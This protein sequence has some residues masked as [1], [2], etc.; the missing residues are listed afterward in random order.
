MDQDLD[1]QALDEPGEASAPKKGGLP[2]GGLIRMV[3]R[4]IL[5]IGGMTGAL[6]IA[7]WLSTASD[8][9]TYRGN[10]QLLVEP[11][12]SEARIA[13]PTALTRSAG[14]VPSRDIFSLDYPTQLQILRSPKVLEEVYEKVQ[15][16]YPAFTYFQLI[17]GLELG[18]IGNTR[19]TETKILQV[20]YS[21]SD[22]ELVQ[23]VLNELASKYLRY[24][25]EDR[26]SRISEGVKFIEDQL[27]SLQRRVAELE[28]QLQELQQS[29]EL[30]DPSS[31]GGQIFSQLQTVTEQ[32][33]ATQQQIQEQRVL[34]NTLQRQLGLSPNE[35]IAASALSQDP[36]YQQLLSS[37]NEIDS[38]I[39][40]E[41]SRF[42][43]ESPIIQRLRQ[44]QANLTTVLGQQANR[45]LGPQLARKAD[46]LTYQDSLRLGLIQQ[47]ITTANEMQ[48]LQMRDQFLARRQAEVSRQVQQFPA[49]ARRYAEI[50][51]ELGVATRTLD[52]LLGQRETLRVEAAQTQVPWEL[53][54]EPMLPR[55]PSGAAI[56]DPNSSRK[57][58]MMG[59]VAGLVLGL[60]TAVLIEKRQNIFF[61]AEDVK[62]AVPVPLLGVLPAC[63]TADPCG[64]L[65]SIAPSSGELSE[66]AF[67]FLDAVNNFY[68]SLRFLN[69]NNLVRSLV[70][71]SPA[72]G[73]GKTTTA[74]HLA[75]TAAAA[76][77]RVLLVD[78]NLRSPKL[79]S[80][81]NLPN[82]CGLSELLAQKVYPE[83]A[84][85]ECPSLEHLCILTAG[86]TPPG[87][88][89]MLASPQM[90]DLMAAFDAQFDLI[91][92]DTPNLGSTVDA[93]FLAAQADGIL[94]VLAV[95]QT[96]YSKTKEVLKKLE[97]FHLPIIGT[98]ANRAIAPAE[99]SEEDDEYDEYDEDSEGIWAAAAAELEPDY[100]P[101]YNV[102]VDDF[103]DVE[104]DDA[105]EAPQPVL[106]PL[107]V[108]DIAS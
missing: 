41:S 100:N 33:V 97:E 17:Q 39:A 11:V 59:M 102:D 104:D 34:Y 19:T 101:A 108:D 96:A 68:A 26:K 91:L 52:Q 31:Q 15:A 6:S 55:D 81:L 45:I 14:G 43:D 90:K 73:D 80:I 44:R 92:Y 65:L 105:D 9:P 74:L 75:Q 35:A 60:G 99:V 107:F 98:V 27:P 66:D 87:T 95:R 37:I 1:L 70:V 78:A 86:Q 4:K 5:I 18:R 42:T 62:D 38:Q 51:R 7:A 88:T 50:Q 89:K 46:S 21:G 29:Y 85:Q 56:P 82:E 93:N 40:L 32:Q 16:K 63:A 83:D 25:L 76:G 23:M 24:S 2:I 12:T 58:L 20:G 8:L 36:R 79:H 13:E 53:I 47:L 28:K 77:Q 48:V 10:F 61:G 106:D 84:I 67:P 64:S 22:A 54:S 69:P 103:E 94:L 3:K 49:I 71:C 30:I 57:K 72:A